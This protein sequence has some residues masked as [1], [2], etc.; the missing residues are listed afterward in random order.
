MLL[1]TATSAR[2]AC[3]MHMTSRALCLS[4]S[5]LLRM[6]G[7][8]KS[9]HRTDQFPIG[10]KHHILAVGLRCMAQAATN[11]REHIRSRQRRMIFAL[12]ATASA[13]SSLAVRSRG[14]LMTAPCFLV[15]ECHSVCVSMTEPE[16]F[17][18][19][20]KT[21]PRRATITKIRMSRESR[22]LRAPRV[23]MYRA[24]W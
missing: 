16:M 8:P 18:A 3:E 13:S 23:P 20:E 4:L 19:G 17:A 6:Y 10:E 11:L 5:G 1:A 24:G 14:P 15:G 2:P 9:E 22:R 12:H 21:P 7:P